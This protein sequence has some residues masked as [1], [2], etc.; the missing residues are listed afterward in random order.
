M[1]G[2]EDFEEKLT[3]AF[4]NDM[5][6]LKN[7][8]GLLPPY[9]RDSLEDKSMLFH[10]KEA[11]PLTSLVTHLKVELTAYCFVLKATRQS[12][13]RMVNT[14]LMININPIYKR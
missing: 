3:C 6:N 2:T 4:K 8:H 13:Q 1:F 5:R 12:R 11:F 14:L 9:V 7:L 10:F